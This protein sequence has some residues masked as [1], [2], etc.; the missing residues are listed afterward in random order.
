MFY[1]R[2]A[3]ELCKFIYSIDY[4][5]VSHSQINERPDTARKVNVVSALKLFGLILIFAA[6]VRGR[7]KIK[8]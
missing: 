5:A 6:V 7:D 2:F 3:S 8:S 1:S 4:V